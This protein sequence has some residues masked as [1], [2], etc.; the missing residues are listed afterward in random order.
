MQA[1]NMRLRSNGESF[2]LS[3][4][5]QAKVTSAV[6]AAPKPR[7]LDVLTGGH[8]RA[9]LARRPAPRPARTFGDLPVVAEAPAQRD[10]DGRQV[11]QAV[12]GALHATVD[13][14]AAHGL[15]GLV[16]GPGPVVGVFGE[17]GRVP[18]GSRKK[19]GC[20]EGCSSPRSPTDTR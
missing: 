7:L 19:R 15:R 16:G 8:T 5:A 14:G 18:A 1:S 6:S 9:P 20:P 2:L 13:A 3:L 11:P 12:R 4:A 17:P 10:G